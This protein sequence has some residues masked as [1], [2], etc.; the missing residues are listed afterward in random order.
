MSSPKASTTST[1]QD[2]WDCM[3]PGPP[4]RKNFGS[5]DLS[6]FGLLAF[7]SGSSISVLNARSMQLVVNIPMP[8][9]TKSSS[10]SSSLSP[11]VTSVRWT[12][13]PLRRDLLSTEP[14]SSHLFLA[15]GD[16]QGH[17]ALLDLCLKSPVLWFDTDSSPSKLA[18]QDLAWVQARPDSYLIASISG[19]SSLSLYNSSTGRCF[20]K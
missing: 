6:L 7:P 4:S 8:P 14:S 18:I 3:L 13:L 11:F 5:T 15:A 1:V 16:H 9:P 12:P 20:W 2:Y 10:T 19:F 17:I